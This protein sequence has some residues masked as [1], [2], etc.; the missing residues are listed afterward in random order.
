MDAGCVVYP[1]Y[2]GVVARVGWCTETLAA[3]GSARTHR[4]QL[5]RRLGSIPGMLLSIPHRMDPSWLVDGPPCGRLAAPWRPSALRT[6]ERLN[7]VCQSHP[8]IS[9]F[10]DKFHLADLRFNNHIE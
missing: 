4:K 6:A 5:R 10:W 9:Y 1:V 8:E 2:H 3:S 7:A